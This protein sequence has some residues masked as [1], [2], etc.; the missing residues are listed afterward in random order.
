ME[1]KVFF[2]SFGLELWTMLKLNSLN[3]DEAGA[4]RKQGPN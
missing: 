3:V 2:F 1:F 4:I